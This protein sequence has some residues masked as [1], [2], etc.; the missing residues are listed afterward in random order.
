MPTIGGRDVNYNLCLP[1]EALRASKERNSVESYIRS[2]EK[3]FNFSSV[4]Q[5][6]QCL[7]CIKFHSRNESMTSMASMTSMTKL[8]AKDLRCLLK[9]DRHPLDIVDSMEVK[10]LVENLDRSVNMKRGGT[11]LAFY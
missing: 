8:G 5:F 2:L 7:V 4:G 9:D 1:E 6:A 10:N 3:H 11:W